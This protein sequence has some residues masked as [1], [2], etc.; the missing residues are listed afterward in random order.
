MVQTSQ[1]ILAYACVSAF[2]IHFYANILYVLKKLNDNNGARGRVDSWH[3]TL[4]GS[5]TWTTT[6]GEAVTCEVFAGESLCLCFVQVIQSKYLKKDMMMLCWI[7]C[8]S[9]SANIST[10][11]IRILFIPARHNDVM[12]KYSHRKVTQYAYCVQRWKSIENTE[13]SL[14]FSWF[15]FIRNAFYN[16]N[17][18][19]EMTY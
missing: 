8:D 12:M 5:Q 7:L 18:R 9:A 4:L 15:L 3:K 13:C 10:P 19:E 11:E 16:I 1:F 14:W 2:I 6:R 17:I